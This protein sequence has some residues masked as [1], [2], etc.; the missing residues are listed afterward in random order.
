[1]PTMSSG[2]AK[3]PSPCR[4]PAASSKSAPGVRIVTAAV[5]RTWPA[6]SRISR[7]SSVAS[8]SERLRDPA[9]STATTLAETEEPGRSDPRS[10]TEE[11]HRG[12]EVGGEAALARVGPVGCSGLAG[13]GRLPLRL[14][15]QPGSERGED[16][17]DPALS[18]LQAGDDTGGRR[19]RPDRVQ[20]LP[21][22]R[23]DGD[24]RRLA[25]PETRKE[26][27]YGGA[28]RRH[29]DRNHGDEV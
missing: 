20:G 13:L 14:A 24:D 5:R 16:A 25:P 4:K 27:E 3:M 11:V 15:D 22:A 1:M 9:A 2:P 6:T 23:H 26:G 18:R 10:D 8:R 12:V 7:G 28:G 29:V 19:A 21:S 17:H